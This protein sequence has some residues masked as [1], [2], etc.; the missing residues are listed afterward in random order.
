MIGYF[1]YNYHNLPGKN[2][3]QPNPT[4]KQLANGQ[5]SGSQNENQSST[6]PTAKIILTNSDPNQPALTSDSPEN[7]T[8]PSPPPSDPN[9][10]PTP[11][12]PPSP[13]CPKEFIGT[14]VSISGNQVTF[15]YG[16]SQSVAILLTKTSPGTLPPGTVA[17]V[18]AK[19]QN[20]VCVEDEIEL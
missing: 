10:P 16:D 20:N 17:H 15:S 5:T 11:P 12:P 19:L 13:P 9:P 6:P 18:H 8:P 14:V 7:Q 1:A 4:N 3:A 2:K